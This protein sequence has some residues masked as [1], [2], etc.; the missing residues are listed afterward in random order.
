MTRHVTSDNSG[1]VLAGE[2]LEGTDKDKTSI[3]LRRRGL[4][5]NYLPCAQSMRTL[6]EQ[7]VEAVG[8][9]IRAH[10]MWPGDSVHF[11]PVVQET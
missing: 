11:H 10:V 3:D 9:V 6:D 7:G 8:S 5:T 2:D 1:P 4:D